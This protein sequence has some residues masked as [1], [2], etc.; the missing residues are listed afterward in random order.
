MASV[1]QKTG[2]K[3]AAAAVPTREPII[4][5]RKTPLNRS[6]VTRSIRI[7]PMILII[8]VILPPSLLNA[9]DALANADLRISTLTEPT[10][11]DNRAIGTS[12]KNPARFPVRSPIGRE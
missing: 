3:L 7:I 1:G 11:V 10:D 4:W 8:T 5:I 9:V 2:T 12:N 6:C